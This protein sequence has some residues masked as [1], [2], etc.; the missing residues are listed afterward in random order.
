MACQP[1]P[2]AHSVVEGYPRQVWTDNV[3]KDVI[4]S[5]TIARMAHGTPLASGAA[6]H[7]C[8]VAGPF[9]L[10]VR[11]SSSYHIAKFFGVARVRP[12]PE[13]VQHSIR[14]DEVPHVDR[15]PTTAFPVDREILMPNVHARPQ[16]PSFGVGAVIAK[17]VKAAGLIKDG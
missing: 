11:I 15:P 14:V 2:R 12:H 4:E 9:L 1:S 7:E 16:H 17:A 8:G 6:D 13:S 10:D 3:G 5:Y